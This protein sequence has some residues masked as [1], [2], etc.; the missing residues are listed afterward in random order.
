VTIA[1]A[2]GLTTAHGLEED[3]GR[4]EAARRR[5]RRRRTAM[6]T[7]GAA[8]TSWPAMNSST[9]LMERN[10]NNDDDYNVS[11]PFG[12][13]VETIFFYGCELVLN[14]FIWATFFFYPT[15]SLQQD[16]LFFPTL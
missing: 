5:R 4:R 7:M 14:F 11:A 16:L 12:H 6:M 15:R 1:A 10:N 8:S 9:A 3:Y 13:E 2:A